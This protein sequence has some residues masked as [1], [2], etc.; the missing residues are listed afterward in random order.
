MPLDAVGKELDLDWHEV[1]EVQ[2]SETAAADTVLHELIR[3]YSWK[4]K[5]LRRSRV[6]ISGSSSLANEN[7]IEEEPQS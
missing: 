1:A 6:V 4:G 2:G 5:L 7:F 3:G